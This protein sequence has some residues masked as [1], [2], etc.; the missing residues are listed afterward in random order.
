MT[1]LW[2]GPSDLSSGVTFLIS[3]I[4][5]SFTL[6]LENPVVTN[7][8]SPIQVNLG[9]LGDS[10]ICV[11]NTALLV[12]GSK[13]YIFFF[14]LVTAT[15]EPIGFQSRLVGKSEN[16]PLEYVSPFVIFQICKE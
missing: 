4:F 10:Y 5:N 9:D 1:N 12:L 15:K 11:S 3:H 6:D 7:S 13:T 14:L 2:T 16:S 8:F